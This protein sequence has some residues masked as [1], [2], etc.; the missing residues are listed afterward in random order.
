MSIVIREIEA[1]DNRAVADL[2][3]KV[4]VEFNVPKVGT[5]YADT[6]LDQMYES[7]QS[8]DKGVY[9]VIED[10]GEVIGCAG[11]CQLDNYTGPV[12]ELQKMYFLE[13][14]R[15]R[16]LGA[17]MMQ[18]CL[19]TARGLGFE[20]CYLETMPQMEAAQV[21]Y[22][23]TGFDYIDGPLGDTGHHSCPVHMIIDL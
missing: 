15:G 22:R 3:R 7:Y 23:K 10:D 16:G 1:K 2:I 14:A 6:A 21:L 17:Q 11:V 18:K 4:L 8:K 19:D 13:Q 5:A 12:C 20:K 9:F